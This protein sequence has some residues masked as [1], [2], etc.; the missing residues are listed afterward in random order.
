MARKPPTMRAIIN[1]LVDRTN[2]DTQRIRILEQREGS[3]AMR[4]DSVEQEILNMNNSLLKISKDLDLAF[5]KRD[6]TISEMRGTIR[7][8][9][10]HIKGLANAGR[11]KEL[12]ATLNL[13]NPLKSN[14]ATKEEVERIVN[15]KL[16]SMPKNNK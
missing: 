7:D 9:L 10:K 4:L 8:I 3:L 11:V 1:E 12:E 2:T 13:Y 14:F 16:S 15:K 5:R 6:V